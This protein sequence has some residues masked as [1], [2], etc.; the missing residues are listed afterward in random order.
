MPNM[1]AK[2]KRLKLTEQ[3][4][5]AITD[6][7]ESRYR[8]CKETGLDPATLH[9]FTTGERGL[10]MEAL[11]AVADYLGLSIVVNRKPVKRRNSKAAKS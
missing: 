11:D 2:I 6:S 9:R 7:G 10:S 1:A 3:V 4:R 5:Q 8:I